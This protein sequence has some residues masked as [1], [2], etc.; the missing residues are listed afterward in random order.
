MKN[1]DKQ[2]LDNLTLFRCLTRDDIIDLHFKEL[3]YPIPAANNVLKRLR[4]QGQITANTRQQPY[5]YFTNPSPIKKDSQKIPHF[6]AIANVYKQLIKYDMPKFFIVEPKFGKDYMEPDILC[7]WR[8]NLFFIE[9]QLSIYSK[10]VM[11]AKME[12]YKAYYESLK[13]EEETWQPKNQK[14]FPSVLI[15]TDTRYAIDKY[16]FGVFQT[17]SIDD[18]VESIPSKETTKSKVVTKPQQRTIVNKS[19][20]NITWKNL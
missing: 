17:P 7:R 6:L 5:V 15:I 8:G 12:R 4:L 2:I 3:K 19:P 9:V 18:F 14:I 13:W 11:Y 20:T 16:P 10:K 1:R